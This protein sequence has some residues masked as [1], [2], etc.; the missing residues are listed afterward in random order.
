M[1]LHAKENVTSSFFCFF[2]VELKHLPPH[3]LGYPSLVNIMERSSFFQP[4]ALEKNFLLPEIHN[5]TFP[6]F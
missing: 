5:I 3:F 4:P 1:I 6:L 2:H